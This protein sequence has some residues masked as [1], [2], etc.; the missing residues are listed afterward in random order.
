M[1]PLPR[2]LL[3]VLAVLLVAAGVGFFF[4]EPEEPAAPQRP[5]LAD[6]AGAYRTG[7]LPDDLDDAVDVAVEGLPLALAYD[8]RSLRDGLDSATALMTEDFS[9][10][11]R[12]TFQRSAAK[13]ARTQ[14]AVTSATVRSA[15]VVRI[16]D[17]SV[18]TL[19][20]VDQ[21]LVSSTTLQDRDQPV[22]VS[23]NRVLVGLSD[24][25]G[26]WRIDSITPI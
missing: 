1:R 4:L 23:Q 24:D 13:L 14:Q 21:V 11:F 18:L 22:R 8:Y 17:D 10:E 25:D 16:E 9:E 3:P 5:Q 15:G 12:R 20:Y 2:F 7:S 6:T 26:T 19:V